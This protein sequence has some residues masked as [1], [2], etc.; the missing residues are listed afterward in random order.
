MAL[1]NIA[2]FSIVDTVPAT[3]SGLCTVMVP[4]VAMI[5]GAVFHGEPLGVLEIGAMTCCGASLLMVL[6]KPGRSAGSR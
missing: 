1:G 2:W 4:M 3:I 6:W 5:T